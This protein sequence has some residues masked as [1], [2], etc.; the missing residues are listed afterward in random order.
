[1]SNFAKNNTVQAK[2]INIYIIISLI[3]I[4]CLSCYQKQV[5][6]VAEP[7]YGDRSFDI[8][9]VSSFYTE[10]KNSSKERIHNIKIA[11]SKLD[12]VFLESGEEFS[13]NKTVGERSAKNG[14][15]DANIIVDKKF[16]SGVGGGVCQVST[17]LYNAVILAGLKVTEYHPHTLKVNY[18]YPSFDAMVSYGY[19]DFR[20]INTTLHPIYLSVKCDDVRLRITI[21]GQ[22]DG[23]TYK[24][25]YS[26][27]DKI[28]PPSPIVI[29]DLD[30][31]YGVTGDDYIFITYPKDG[32]LSEG[33]LLKYKGDKL[34]SKKLIRKDKY[35]PV[36]G[37]IV[38]APKLDEN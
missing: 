32:L 18:V 27:L 30:G 1:M 37:E 16:I 5:C 25:E 33:Y 13:F 35:L 7:F 20:F 29:E 38:I 23:Y 31:I 22:N 28:S 12:G 4:A 2:K 34:I 9:E 26:V 6:V 8:E 15:L 17:T 24:R 19:A 36:T 14:Y 11:S 10:Y 3:T 21:Y